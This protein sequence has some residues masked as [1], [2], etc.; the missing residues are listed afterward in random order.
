MSTSPPLV[1]ADR[2][3]LV[4]PLGQGGM[5]RV[6]RATDVVLHRD[7]A[8]K[9]LVP[10]PGL[11]PE[12]RQEMRE[13]SLREARAIAR[14]NN[15]NVVRVFD[16]LRTDADP[17][18]VMEYVPSRSLQDILAADGPFGPVRAAEIGLGVLGALRAAHRAGVVHRDV[19]PGNVLIGEDGRVVLTDFGLA[20][21]PG[22]PNVT[23]TGLVLGSPAYIAPERARDGT[24]G[25]GADLWSL[26][27]TLYAAVE[28]ASPFARP[29]AI[30]TLAALATENPPPA[31]NAG[32][33][34]PVLNGLLRKDPAHRINAEE[35]ERLLLRATGR[36]SK[37]AF[38]MSPTMRRPGVGR[39]RPSATITPPVVPGSAPV[40]PGPRPPVT[41]GRPP[42]TPGR[43]PVT[44]PVTPGRSPVTPPAAQGRPAIGQ[45]RPPGVPPTEGRPPIFA[46]GK[47]SVGRVRPQAETPT[48]ADGPK[49]PALDAT[50]VDGPKPPPLDATRI[51]APHPD[52]SGTG[53]A[54]PPQA[55]S[56]AARRPALDA[57]MRGTGAFGSITAAE[58]AA[59]RRRVAG[60]AT[61]AG[62][63]AVAPPTGLARP[64]AP[65]GSTQPP[66]SAHSAG[67]ARPSVSSPGSAQS[68]GPAGSVRPDAVAQGSA[69]APSSAQ[70]TPGGEPVT[71]SPRGLARVPKAGGPPEAP[72][73][74]AATAEP[75]T[76]ESS[77]PATVEPGSARRPFGPRPG[78]S[79]Q[80]DAKSG[81]GSESSIPQAGLAGEAAVASRS[82]EQQAPGDGAPSAGHAPGTA[83]SGDAD[84]SA[85]SVGEAGSAGAS[86]EPADV[87]IDQTDAPAEPAADEGE[88]AEG[89]AAL[90]LTATTSGS[91]GSDAPAVEAV[92]GS[93][94]S[95]GAESADELPVDSANAAA[96][97]GEAD[98]AAGPVVV[99]DAADQSA[100]AAGAT[101]SVD[102]AAEAGDPVE[103]A[104]AA[105]GTVEL[106]SAAGGTAESAEA[107]AR[108]ADGR[109]TKSAGEKATGSAEAVGTQAGGEAAESAVAKPADAA[110]KPAN[111]A[112]AK[113]GSPA[114]AA[115]AD[116]KGSA[117]TATVEPERSDEA[118]GGTSDDSGTA[119]ESVGSAHTASGVA[120]IGAAEAGADDA[121][122]ADDV[123]PADDAKPA[124]VTRPA[125][126][127]SRKKG[128]TRPPA[129]AT[130]AAAAASTATDKGGATVADPAGE[131]DPAVADPAV[132]DPAGEADLAV[133]DPAVADPAGEAGAVVAGP[134]GET[135]ADAV[136]PAR[137]PEEPESRA[138][139]IDPAKSKS[140]PE[141][142][143]QP[144]TRED[145][146]KAADQTA[147]LGVGELPGKESETKAADPNQTRVVPPAARR[148]PRRFQSAGSGAPQ[149]ETDAEYPAAASV[150]GAPGFGQ[151]SRPAWQPM[152]VRAPSTGGRGLTVFGVTLTRRQTVI[153]IAL[154]AAVLLAVVLLVPLAF[155]DDEGGQA[156]DNGRK[157]GAVPVP[158]AGA[159]AGSVPAGSAPAG[160]APA[161]TPA[162]PPSSPVATQTSASP[163]ASSGSVVLPKGWYMYKDGSGFSV[164]APEGASIRHEGSE[165]Y[166]SKNNRLLIVDQTGEPQPD[167]VADWRAQEKARRGGYRNYS[168]IKIVAA[169]YYV[170]AADWEFTY[171]T[172]SGNPQ[173]VVKRGFITTPGKQAYGLSWYVSPDEWDSSQKDLQ[174]I[175][176]GFKPKS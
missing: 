75:G 132:A 163:V 121:K 167:P 101:A 113:D 164:P 162:Q 125:T 160:P 52:R 86:A 97:S 7:V 38:P 60:Q 165:V 64:S 49:P 16:V 150:S 135:R 54:P 176:Q 139:S 74:K 56:P 3:R 152:T 71:R 82:G 95:V 115:G 26:G 119:S 70:R 156:A 146:T 62:G 15:I 130:R 96:G 4:A 140:R 55:D 158:S 47:A 8:I 45:G 79:L 112:S 137:N 92:E 161:T 144:T 2:Y 68:A 126:K 84:D 59:H 61:P 107:V 35:A 141:S 37:L 46:P 69:Q 106:A 67:L 88:A 34:K 148:P 147:L 138:K 149:A 48:R 172:S 159:S 40:V 175:Y 30:A 104:S 91:T 98:R 103:L 44:P 50:R 39:E 85:V 13:R 154:L 142:A 18:I 20:T 89:A 36:R 14:L 80:D 102:E 31:R 51:D 128:R 117:G 120:G 100:P 143:D 28:G 32:P 171:T 24:A 90:A 41:P 170:K 151:S 72:E 174:L 23:R 25:P 1:V 58:V 109:K 118:E 53:A 94:D 87:A 129:K 105:G 99:N 83:D 157:A 12:E 110:A 153:G 145:R 168:L 116:P 173:H 93:A 123:K 29:S 155:G 134:A 17:W 65:P 73:A 21:V 19:K 77:S 133:A 42:V 166:I 76:V 122:P 6:W 5:G 10:P 43:P 169:D 81:E 127:P 111:E 108:P 33:L 11:T 63:A 22:D 124:A 9:E 114:D 66:G 78:K 131:A 27:A 57:T 136:T